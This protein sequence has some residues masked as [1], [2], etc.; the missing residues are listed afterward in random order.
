P[1]LL[2]VQLVYNYMRTWP[3]TLHTETG[4]LDKQSVQVFVNKQ[5]LAANG[6]INTAGAF[7]YNPAM[8]R[9]I[10]DGLVYK[11]VG[12]TAVAQ[13]GSSDILISFIL[14]REETPTG[15]DR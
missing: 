9:F 2:N 7:D 6:H 5:Y 1:I 12:D 15:E 3:I 14:K 4:E 8:D 11:A 10:I 13:A